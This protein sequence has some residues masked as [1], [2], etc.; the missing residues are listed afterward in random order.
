M[1]GGVLRWI[2]GRLLASVRRS[3][4]NEGHIQGLYIHT[5]LLLLSVLQAWSGEATEM[6]S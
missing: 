4:W 3:P 5:G 1:E 2:E 6:S